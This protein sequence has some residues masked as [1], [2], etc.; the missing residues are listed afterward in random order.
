MR[1][2]TRSKSRSRQPETAGNLSLQP[3]YYV[4]T[5]LHTGVP[6]IRE[7]R[8]RSNSL[9]EPFALVPGEGVYY[10]P[11]YSQQARQRDT[12]YMAGYSPQ[13]MHYPTHYFAHGH[14][15]YHQQNPQNSGYDSSPQSHYLD[16][17]ARGRPRSNT[18]TAAR[19][20]ILMSSNAPEVRVPLAGY[21]PAPSSHEGG[22]SIG[23]FGSI[24]N[25]VRSR[26]KSR[27]RDALFSAGHSKHTASSYTP[28][29]ERGRP[30]YD[31]KRQKEML[32]DV[33]AE[34]A[35]RLEKDLRLQ[36]LED[37][38]RPLRR[39]R[40]R[41]FESTRSRERQE[42]RNRDIDPDV[43]DNTRYNAKALAYAPERH[44]PVIRMRP[45]QPH[46]NSGYH[47]D[48]Q[49]SMLRRSNTAAGHPKSHRSSHLPTPKGWFNS[50]G[51][52]LVAHGSVIRQP[53]DREFLPCFAHYPAP[54]QGFADSAGN[55][56]DMDGRLVKRVG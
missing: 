7:K 15:V 56:V 42:R 30:V 37:P 41:S 35:R 47:T 8:K 2:F 4:D 19:E 17:H 24:V 36:D 34:I 10:R 22:K 38:Y 40:S 45:D 50:R 6:V 44:S 25:A 49:P 52:Q 5:P 33:D 23:I 1:L 39:D 28:Q 16:S 26:S 31:L 21:A 48:A 3:S 20:K 18:S 12:H 46:H 43:Q 54:G 13:T 27:E 51:D 29:G 9:V 55:V 11:E 14:V 32:R 53:P